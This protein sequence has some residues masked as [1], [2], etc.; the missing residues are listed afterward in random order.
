MDSFIALAAVDPP[1]LRCLE[2]TATGEVV[3]T[4]IPPADPAGEF[5]E[6]IV[7][8]AANVSGPYTSTTVAGIA[9]NSFTISTVN[10]LTAN[11]YVYVETVYNDG[12]GNIQVSS[13]TLATILIQLTDQ[14]DT[15]A[16]LTWNK[17]HD[18]IIPT[19]NVNYSVYRR[20][21]TTGPWTLIGTTPFGTETY[22]DIFKVC[23]ETIQYKIEVEDASGCI[24]ISAIAE[25]LF[26]DI[27]APDPPVI[28]SV[29]VD[30][31]T[32]NILLGW[33][34][35]RAGDTD[36]YIVTY[37]DLTPPTPS[38]LPIATLNGKSTVFYL[39]A[40]ANGNTAFHEYGVAAFDS[41]VITTNPNTSAIDTIVHRTMFMQATLDYCAKE[42]NVFWTPYVGWR[43]SLSGYDLFVEIDGAAP[44]LIASLAANDTD[45]VHENVDPLKTY[46]YYA[47]AYY[48]NKVKSSTSNKFCVVAGSLVTPNAHYLM[49]VSV[50]ENEYVNLTCYVDPT[51]A[52]SYYS[53]ERAIRPDG[54]FL[55][56]GTIVP[57][58]DTIVQY[59]DYEAPFEQTSFY[60]RVGIID[61]CGIALLYSNVSNTVHLDGQFDKNLFHNFLNW[62]PYGDW[63]V[64]GNGVEA[65]NIYRKLNGQVEAVP[66]F[67]VNNS[68]FAIIDSL[69]ETVITSGKEVCFVVE[70]VES[71]GN[72]FGF[73]ESSFSNEICFTANPVIWIPNAFAPEGV[74]NEFKPVISFGDWRSY[75]MQIFDRYGQLLFE[76]S[77]QDEGWDGKVDGRYASI[78][79][80]VYRIT[81]NNF[82]G[83]QVQ[84]TGVL[85]LVR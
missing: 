27:W 85:T 11:Q 49:S 80:Y 33:Q 78:G 61:S 29:S 77:D 28:D 3:A 1:E 69:M 32:G 35:S 2:V 14:T 51:V 34:E 63:L 12:S 55:E 82:K 7:N 13:D 47:R 42:N 8:V 81:I 58:T 62:S 68:Q 79:S 46:C 40:V 37:H 6:Y 41:C 66:S 44:Q 83:D 60:Y 4:W 48:S 10:A 39:D 64:H 9:T 43:D 19:H 67:S 26:Q 21:G 30:I 59:Q 15:T 24:N 50:I 45:F 20:F 17:I 56:I 5:V 23:S 73:K 53:V 31:N 22:A 52:V 71:D 25:D 75:T 65:Y 76:T 74:N 54:P 36:G 18:P 16:T 84:R 38:W 72:A 57:S 70:A